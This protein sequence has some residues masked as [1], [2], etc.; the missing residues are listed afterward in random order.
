MNYQ[1]AITA[2]QSYGKA[3]E[4]AWLSRIDVRALLLVTVVYL[5]ALLSMPLELP[6]R[7]IWFAAYPIIMSPLCGISY[8]RIFLNSLYVGPFILLIGMFNPLLDH[9]Q[10]FILGNITVTMG[11]LT[12]LSILIRGLL[13]MQALL[14]LIKM[15]GFPGLCLG[16]RKTGIPKVLVVQLFFLYRFGGLLLEEMHRMQK[17]MQSRGY[18]RKSY[19]LKLWT[20]VVGSLL[21][22]ALQRSKRVHLAME[23]RGFQGEMPGFSDTKVWNISDTCFCIFCVGG[24]FILH[25]FDFTRLFFS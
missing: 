23:S 1:K 9:R 24:I 2:Y 16:L 6:D 7:L 25:Y 3:E 21:L 14:I 17:S 4:E 18:G 10:A 5:I 15:R 22:R 19:P 8:S 20:R 13:A 11:W 12:F